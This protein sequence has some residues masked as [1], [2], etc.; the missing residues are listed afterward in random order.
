[1]KFKNVINVINYLYLKVLHQKVL[2]FIKFHLP[3]NFFKYLKYLKSYSGLKTN[4]YE[5]ILIIRHRCKYF[6]KQNI[7]LFIRS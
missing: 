5:L 2:N 4:T 3:F 6:S 7:F 1:M